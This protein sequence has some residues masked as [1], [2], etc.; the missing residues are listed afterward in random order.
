MQATLQRHQREGC[1]IFLVVSKNREVPP[2]AVS[3]LQRQED[4]GQVVLKVRAFLCRQQVDAYARIVVPV[5]VVAEVEKEEN[6][7]PADK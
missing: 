3:L 6:S 2:R 4:M 1:A 5:V 7:E